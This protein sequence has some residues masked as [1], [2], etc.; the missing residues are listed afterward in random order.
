M[1]HLVGEILKHPFVIDF[2]KDLETLYFNDDNL[3][4]IKKI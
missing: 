2:V 3:F 1:T 4:P